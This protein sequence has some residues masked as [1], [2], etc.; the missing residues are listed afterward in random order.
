M[1]RT[2]NSDFWSQWKL[3]SSS[4][5]SSEINHYALIQSI[6]SWETKTK[7]NSTV[8]DIYWPEWQTRRYIQNRVVKFLNLI[9]WK[10]QGAKSLYKH[11][12][13]KTTPHKPGSLKFLTRPTF[14][15]LSWKNQPDFYSF[16]ISYT[17][18]KKPI[19]PKFLM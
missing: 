16:K 6:K 2:F 19:V 12:Q 10:K 18:P 8:R 13:F 17:F 3:S 7:L 1:Q 9:C 15:L 5:I 14:L 11:F 4:Y